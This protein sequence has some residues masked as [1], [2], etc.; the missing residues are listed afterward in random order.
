MT[1]GEQKFKAEIN[2]LILRAIRKQATYDSIV[3]VFQSVLQDLEKM[4]PFM[5]AARDS[6]FRP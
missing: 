6:N 4:K 5:V 2:D 1:E 3:S